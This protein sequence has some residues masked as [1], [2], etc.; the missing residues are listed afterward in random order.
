MAEEALDQLN[1]VTRNKYVR[2]IEN[3]EE[4]KEGHL[5]PPPYSPSHD[6]G[7]ASPV[8]SSEVLLEASVLLGSSLFDQRQRDM[9]ASKGQQRQLAVLNISHN[10]NIEEDDSESVEETRKLLRWEFRAIPFL[11]FLFPHFCNDCRSDFRS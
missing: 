9:A 10:H 3:N 5:S 11:V 8:F 7:A 1:N 2:K 6:R 4:A